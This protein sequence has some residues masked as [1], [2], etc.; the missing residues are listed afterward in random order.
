ML[1]VEESQKK[2]VLLNSSVGFFSKNFKDIKP[3]KMSFEE[4]E[5]IRNLGGPSSHRLIAYGYDPINDW[6]I[7][8]VATHTGPTWYKQGMVELQL[9][10]AEESGVSGR[11]LSIM[12][13]FPLEKIEN[14][15]KIADL[16]KNLILDDF[17]YKEETRF[18]QE[19]VETILIF[20]PYAIKTKGELMYLTL[21]N[22]LIYKFK[23][24]L[25]LVTIINAMGKELQ[26]GK[27]KS[28]SWRARNNEDIAQELQI[29]EKNS[30]FSTYEVKSENEVN[31]VYVYEKSIKNLIEEKNQDLLR[32]SDGASIATGKGVN[33]NIE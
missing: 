8:Q 5:I 16:S 32:V 29:I 14:I 27:F 12:I 22:S 21:N 24:E 31:T 19:N 25:Q 3:T 4:V 23:E 1:K 11:L 9:A 2:E 20:N 18:I 13:A 10:G 15:V 7:F 28:D 6:V 30:K 17:R 33:T 26:I